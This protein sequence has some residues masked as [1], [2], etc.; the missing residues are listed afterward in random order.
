MYQGQGYTKY[1]YSVCT[2][3]QKQTNKNKGNLH[4]P[5]AISCFK[6]CAY[7][8]CITGPPCG[9]YN[10]MYLLCVCFD[11]L[12]LVN[13]DSFLLFAGITHYTN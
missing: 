8:S 2:K 13:I 11:F 9:I 3:K 7:V 1:M 5:F 10:Y 4:F 6:V 12:D